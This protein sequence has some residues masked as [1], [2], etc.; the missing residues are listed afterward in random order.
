MMKRVISLALCLLM[1][2]AVFAGC[3]KEK[4]ENDFGAYINMYLTDPLYNFDPAMAYGNDSA[5][6]VV[7]LLFDN[8]FILNE[9]GE[10]ENSLAKKY[11]YDEETN[12]MT[13]TLNKTSWSNG[14]EVSADDVICSWRRILDNNNSFAA[15]ALLYDIKNARAAKENING[16][17][18][19]DIGISS[20]GGTELI[21]DFEENVDIDKFIMNLTSY[22]LAPLY[23]SCVYST[24][25]VLDW[26]KKPSLIVTS[27]PFKLREISYN[28]NDRRLVLERNPYYYRNPDLDVIDESVTP[29]RLVVDYT[30]TDAEIKE[31]YENGELFFVGDIPL[32]L[33]GEWKDKATVSDSMSTHTYVL[34]QNAV[35][36]GEKIFAKAEVRQALS[37]VI[38]R[39]EIAKK[40]VFAEAATGLVPK[41]VFNTPEEP[42]WFDSVTTFYEKSSAYLNTTTDQNTINAAKN[43]L[44]T[45]GITDPSKYS[46][47]ISVP[48]YDEVHLLIAGE[49]QKAWKALGFDVTVNAIDVVDNEDK[50]KTI[51]KISGVKDDIFHE[52]YLA[53]DYQVAAIDYVAYSMDPFSV[54]APFAQGYTGEKFGGSTVMEAPIHATGWKDDTYTQ[55]IHEAFTA[56]VEGRANKLHAAEEQLMKQLPIIPIVYNKD[57]VMV[58]D[59]LSDYE[60]TYYKTPIFTKLELEDY[61]DHLPQVTE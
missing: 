4:D 43:K 53:G 7:S 36:N 19:D 16:I 39:E 18:V 58:H 45:V 31:A 33:R 41:A 1:V 59:D 54:L 35:I 20:R 49:V 47:A 56:S 28:D 48:A 30:K 61:H 50:D 24:Y 25:D 9:D 44:A 27:G 22:A 2:V 23:E 11:T 42:G 5:L 34:N 60:F 8:L 51:G 15:A 46:F 32:S 21:I 29:Y 37:E 12:Q 40:V 57:A 52:K 55:L 14:R 26:A 6:K 3:A 13:I 38:N 10:V 17:S